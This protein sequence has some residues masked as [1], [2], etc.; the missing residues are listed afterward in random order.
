M[1]ICIK[2]NDIGVIKEIIKTTS[3]RIKYFVVK[4]ADGNQSE[5]TAKEIWHM[6]DQIS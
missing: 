1:I 2:F 4:W 6:N 5:S 3:H